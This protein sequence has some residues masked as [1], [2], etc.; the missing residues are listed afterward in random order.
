[1]RH[2]LTRGDVA[3]LLG[4]T[5]AAD[6]F[7]RGQAAVVRL[8]GED[9]SRQ[10]LHDA[11]AAHHLHA[12]R[13]AGAGGR[14]LAPAVI[15]LLVVVH[16]GFVVA[17]LW[18]WNKQRLTKALA[19]AAKRQLVPQ[20]VRAGVP[21]VPAPAAG[22]VGRG[23]GPAASRRP[24]WPDLPSTPPRSRCTASTSLRYQPCE[25]LPA[26]RARQSTAP[27]APPRPHTDDRP[28]RD[29]RA[30][31]G[32]PAPSA[33]A[34]ALGSPPARMRVREG[35]ERVRARGAFGAAAVGS[36]PSLS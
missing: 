20:K 9:V 30:V 33:L 2:L 26:G 4:S 24:S 34:D 25:H 11:L 19:G 35:P 12:T 1:M 21:A 31:T 28:T 36:I 15:W 5:S 17:L 22:V 32:D 13:H 18:S 23:G 16:V 27:P 8:P 10:A 29:A 3:G 6:G 14:S 7:G